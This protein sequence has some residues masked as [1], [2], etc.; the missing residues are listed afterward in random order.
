MRAI[1]EFDLDYPDD[2]RA[3]KDCMMV[4]NFRAALYDAY[5][6]LR[7]MAKHDVG[8]TANDSY[9]AFKKAC[10]DNDVDPVDF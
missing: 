3:H 10:A 8:K 4:A 6:M 2:V 9:A 7:E 1:L 5:N